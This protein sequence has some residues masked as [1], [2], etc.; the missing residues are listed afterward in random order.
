MEGEG[1]VVEAPTMCQGPG[2]APMGSHCIG[3]IMCG[4]KLTVIPATPYS[5]HLLCAGHNE[6]ICPS[7]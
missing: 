5:A 6:H 4:G 1:P 3:H 7:Q 2:A